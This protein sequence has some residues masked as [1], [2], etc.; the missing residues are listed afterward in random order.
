MLYK[1]VLTFESGDEMKATQQYFPLVLFKMLYK[2]VLTFESIGEIK[3]ETNQMKLLNSAICISFSIFLH[4]S[5][6]FTNFVNRF[7]LSLHLK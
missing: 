3:S 2:V 7:T 5:R 4:E 1:V 6:N